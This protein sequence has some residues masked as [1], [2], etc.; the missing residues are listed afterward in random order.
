MKCST[1]ISGN[2]NLRYNSTNGQKFGKEN[3]NILFSTKQTSLAGKLD[4]YSK[5]GVLVWVKYLNSLSFPHR[6]DVTKLR[7]SSHIF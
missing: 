4:I 6:R 5:K 3:M 7:I 2:N 1:T